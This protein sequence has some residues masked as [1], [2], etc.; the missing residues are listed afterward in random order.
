MFF[1]QM[2]DADP[3]VFGLN[4]GLEAFDVN[5][6]SLHIDFDITG[7]KVLNTSGQIELSCVHG[8]G[9][10]ETD[11]LNPSLR[12]HTIAFLHSITVAGLEMK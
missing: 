4:G 2:V 12:K 11:T 1:D 9:A 8:T 5:R 3:A 10:P 7:F 6:F